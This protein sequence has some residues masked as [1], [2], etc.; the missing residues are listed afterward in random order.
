MAKNEAANT[1]ITLS[2]DNGSSH[3][4]GIYDQI[5]NTF[6]FPNVVSQPI[7]E[8][9]LLTEQGN[10]LDF[11]D[12]QITSPAITSEQYRHVYVGNLAIGDEGVV[13]E[14]VGDKAA[15]KKAQR[16]ETMVTLLTGAAYA[17]ARKHEAEIRAGLK[18]IK[19]HVYL[20]TGLPISEIA[21]FRAEF[22]AKITGGVHSV[23]FVTTPVYKGVTVELEFSL[24]VDI[25]IDDVSGVYDIEATSKSPLSHKGFGIA[26]VGGVDMD[27]A[28]FRPGLE[29]DQ[30]HSTGTKIHLNDALENIRNEVNAQGE[31]LIASTAELT[32]MLVNKE[33]EI[34]AEGKV[35]FDMT[36]LVNRHMRILAEKVLK[37]ARNAWKHVRYANEFW[38]IGG[39]SIVLQPWIEKLNAELGLPLRFDAAEYSQ[40]R[41]ARGTFLLLSHALETMPQ[42]A[43][44]VE[45]TSSAPAAQKE[46]GKDAH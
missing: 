12:V 9:F 25:G 40:F 41:N 32:E 44:A 4:K 8:R 42:A 45:Q 33:Y 36:G 30:R 1:T 27:I 26:D 16:P 24:P 13:H 15:Q 2:M 17:V 38:F 43:A 6:I 39:G 14:I 22:A 3:I 37:S 34:Y 46:D 10:P 31:E 5:E 28:F 29:L 18:R 23:T 21:K 7:G 20:G 11:L 35:V 19:A